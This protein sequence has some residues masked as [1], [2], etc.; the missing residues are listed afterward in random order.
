MKATLFFVFLLASIFTGKA[1][2]YKPVDDKSEIKFTI[3]N[4]GLNTD[5]SLKGLKGTIKF[6]P[7]NL[8]ASVF[9]VSVDANTVNTGI[10]S[11]DN[12]LRKEDYFDVTQYPTISFVSTAIT[13]TSS[14]YS[15]SGNL[16]I[17]GVERTVSFPFTVEN[18]GD[19]LVFSGNF[20]INRQDFNVGGSSAVLSNTVNVS[21]KV[22][23]VK[24]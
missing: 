23:A 5:G 3:K 11:R 24:G 17:K 21:L 16:T 6:D 7:Q 13:K 18:N 10:D 8:P 4:F 14:G 12:H 15:V 19:A 9:N 1:Q 22:F 2:Q 20:S